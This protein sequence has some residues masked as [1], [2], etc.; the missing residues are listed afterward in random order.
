VKE[1]RVELSDFM[2]FMAIT[3]LRLVEAVES[4]NLIIK[5]ATEGKLSEYYD[6]NKEVLEHYKFKDLFLRKGKKAFVS[7][8]PKDMV[9]RIAEGFTVKSANCIDKSVR[10]SGL[11]SR[12]SDL[13]EFHASI[14]TRHLNQSEID[15]LHGRIGVSTF[16]ANYYNPLWIGDLNQ[17]V[18]KGI[19]EIRNNLAT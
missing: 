6:S 18:F 7:F 10:N 15:F 16:M 1:A 5:L 2:D 11:R 19:N 14:L 8:V 17:R 4:Y 3:G 13:R 9:Q 12:F